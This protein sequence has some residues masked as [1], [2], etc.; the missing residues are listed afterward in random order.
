MYHTP[1]APSYLKANSPGHWPSLTT[2]NE[3]GDAVGPD[4]DPVSATAEIDIPPRSGNRATN[5][6]IRMRM[7][8]RMHG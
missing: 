2:K 4:E 5:M 8:V 3:A 1:P 7:V 6:M